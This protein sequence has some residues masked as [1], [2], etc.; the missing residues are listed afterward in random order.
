MSNIIEALCW[1]MAADVCRRD[2][3]VRIREAHAGGIHSDCLALVHEKYGE[4]A[5]LS[6][7]GCVRI[8]K[9]VTGAS[10]PVMWRPWDSPL[11]IDTNKLTNEFVL[12]LGLPPAAPVPAITARA[13]VYR[14]IAAALGANALAE[15]TWESRSG[16]VDISGFGVGVAEWFAA[17]PALASKLSELTEPDAADATARYWFLLCNRRAVACLHEDGV[18]WP[19]QGASVDLLREHVESNRIWPL[20]EGF[21]A[22]SMD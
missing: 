13:L 8:F 20:V 3:A 12:Q 17:F 19:L 16:Y 4:L 5:N 18:A 22:G 6:P 7:T 10:R 9:H 1:L 14:V 15:S 11:R 2:P 21:V